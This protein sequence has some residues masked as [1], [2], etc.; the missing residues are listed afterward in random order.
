MNKNDIKI[1]LVS[2]EKDEERRKYL[3][4]KPDYTYAVDGSKLD[5]DNLKKENI[6]S[7]DC[8]LKK[9]EIGC[10]LSHVHLL[11]KVVD[12][13]NYTLILED[14]AKVPDDLID[15]IINVI[16]NS[17]KDFEIIFLGYN[18]Y[19]EYYTFKKNSCV[20]GTHAC[21][22]NPKNMTK[23]KINKLFP[24]KKPYD[25]IL[26][27]TFKTYIVIPKIVELNEKFGGISNTQGII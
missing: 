26:P 18:Y 21:L 24:I 4:I 17:P 12:S 22:I 6:I 9:G 13:N 10:F 3:N 14:D 15:K 5:I 23:E 8:T 7:K 27:I 2:L 25:I 1:Y 20:Y 16:E 19:E 11:N